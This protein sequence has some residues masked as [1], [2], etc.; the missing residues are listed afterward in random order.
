V[1]GD[2]REGRRIMINNHCYTND[3]FVA[4]RVQQELMTSE[5]IVRTNDLTHHTLIL[6]FLV[7]NKTFQIPD[8]CQIILSDGKS[9]AVTD[10]QSGNYVT[11]TYETPGNEDVAHEI[12][13]MSVTFIGKVVALNRTNQ[14][15]AA[16]KVLDFNPM[17]F[18]LA[19]NCVIEVNG[20]TNGQLSDLKICERLAFTYN[21]I[22]GVNIVS[23]ITTNAPPALST[24]T[25]AKSPR[26]QGT[27]SP[28]IPI[29]VIR[30]PRMKSMQ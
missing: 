3:V 23:R 6:R 20:K 25:E 12:A 17:E 30:S 2:V 8:D 26:M 13:Q 18:R 9:G 22:N 19:D 11:V 29:Q 4:D 24:A 1:T 21:N 10:I 7:L 27:K 5:G 28:R 15:I 16:A 14:T